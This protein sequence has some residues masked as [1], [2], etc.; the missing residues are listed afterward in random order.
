MP[1][2]LFPGIGWMKIW[3]VHYYDFTLFLDFRHIRHSGQPIHVMS[4]LVQSILNCQAR[5]GQGNLLT[6]QLVAS[7]P[8]L[9]LPLAWKL[10]L[11]SFGRGQ[12]KISIYD[13]V[14]VVFF[15]LERLGSW[16][17]ERPYQE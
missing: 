12:P 13:F 5:T 15:I 11:A 2:A 3:Q 9:Y 1:R 6:L 10:V 4:P 17:F 16:C 8:R 14:Q 7:Q